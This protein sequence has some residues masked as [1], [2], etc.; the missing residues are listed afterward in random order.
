[1]VSIKSLSILAILGISQAF[2]LHRDQS[3]SAILPPTEVVLNYLKNF[4]SNPN[5]VDFHV[6]NTVDENGEIVSVNLNTQ[7]TK[8]TGKFKENYEND[9]YYSKI[10]PRTIYNEDY[11]CFNE[12]DDFG[13][14][15][16]TFDFVD[17]STPGNCSSNGGSKY[18]CV[19][20]VEKAQ[21]A[22][23]SLK[24]MDD[25]AALVRCFHSLDDAK[26]AGATKGACGK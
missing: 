1:M 19:L 24:D 22:T 16:C 5:T 6:I 18:S 11:V 9:I 14:S 3:G 17:Y 20:D 25:V 4:K 12:D 2:N 26:S 13:V 7:S 23:L 8:Q 10:A 15:E 21:D